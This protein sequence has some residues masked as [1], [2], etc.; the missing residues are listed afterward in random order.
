[1]IYLNNKLKIILNNQN[2]MK[3][4]L[5]FT[6]Y[7]AKINIYITFILLFLKSNFKSNINMKNIYNIMKIIMNK[8]NI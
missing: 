6:T 1:M 7:I 8:D 2:I 4:F 3:D 5:N